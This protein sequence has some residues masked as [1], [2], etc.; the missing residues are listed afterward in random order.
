MFAETKIAIIFMNTA[1]S[2]ETRARPKNIGIGPIIEDGDRRIGV[3]RQLAQ[4]HD[5]GLSP[6]ISIDGETMMHSNLSPL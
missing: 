1:V 2:A 5:M 3:K 4:H 6:A